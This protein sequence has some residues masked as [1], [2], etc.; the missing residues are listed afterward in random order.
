MK[1]VFAQVPLGDE[2]AFLGLFDC[3]SYLRPT[4]AAIASAHSAMH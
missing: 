3:V 4:A 2:A 1:L